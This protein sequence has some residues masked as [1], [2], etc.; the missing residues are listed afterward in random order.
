MALLN[1]LQPT[2]PMAAAEVKA[3]SP[4]TDDEAASMPFARALE[5]SRA[6]GD[7]HAPASLRSIGQGDDDHGGR[8]FGGDA[9]RAA[10][11]KCGR[12]ALPDGCRGDRRAG[13]PAP[14]RAAV[15][16]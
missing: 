14:A 8:V 6:E 12:A 13:R 5:R 1:L 2:A 11:K 4:R 7:P 3:G 9:A 10:N 15:S 16:W